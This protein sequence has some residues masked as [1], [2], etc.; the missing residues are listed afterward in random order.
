MHSDFREYTEGL[1]GKPSEAPSRDLMHSYDRLFVAIMRDDHDEQLDVAKQAA[2][3][4]GDSERM[5]LLEAIQQ[6]V[7]PQIDDEEEFLMSSTIRGVP[8]LAVPRLA[9][10][11]TKHRLP[12]F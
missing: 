10:Q 7:Q 11:Q 5:L 12:N 1:K 3:L 9:T 2:A 6:S 4:G 8:G